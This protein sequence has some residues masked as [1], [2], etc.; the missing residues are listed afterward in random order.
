MDPFHVYLCNMY[1]V[2]SVS[3]SLAVTCWESVDLLALMSYTILYFCHFVI[4]RSG[5]GMVLAVKIAGNVRHYEIC[6]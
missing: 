6:A 2:L 1:D 5:P 4:L 3:C